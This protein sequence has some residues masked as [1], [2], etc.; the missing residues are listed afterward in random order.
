MSNVE[1]K[2][3][4]LA[5][6]RVRRNEWIRGKQVVHI[7]HSS[8]FMRDYIRVW[9]KEKW[10][11]DHAVI[12]DYSGARGP[13]CIVPIHDFFMSEF[14][15][16]KRVEGSYANSGYWWS[17]KFPINHELVKLVLSFKDQW[18]VL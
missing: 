3:M 9:W 2:L 7:I 17:Q 8:E 4:N 1:E 18:T 12:F 13:V 6:H 5:Y 11:G 15:K 10:K 16:K 14:V